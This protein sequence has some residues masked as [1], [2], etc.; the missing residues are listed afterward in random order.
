MRFIFNKNKIPF[1]IELISSLLSVAFHQAFPKSFCYK[2]MDYF[3][4]KWPHCWTTRPTDETVVWVTSLQ[5]KVW[6]NANHAVYV[7]SLYLSLPSPSVSRFP[8]FVGGFNNTKCHLNVCG[9]LSQQSNTGGGTLWQ[10]R[11]I[12]LIFPTFYTR[13]PSMLHARFSLHWNK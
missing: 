11:M 10:E 1:P 3:V 5:S 7:L 2:S 9:V 13:F 4:A 12:E 8:S 6:W